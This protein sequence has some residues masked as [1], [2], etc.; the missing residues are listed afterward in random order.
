MQGGHDR[1]PPVDLAA[2]H[3]PLAAERFDAA[4]GQQHP[5]VVI[6]NAGDDAGFDPLLSEIHKSATKSL[7][8]EAIQ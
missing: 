5:V 1:F 3:D 2:R 4:P 8:H 6:Y 7:R